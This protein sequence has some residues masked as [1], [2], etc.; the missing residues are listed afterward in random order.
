MRLAHIPVL[1]KG[2][3]YFY[4]ALLMQI[5]HD[6]VHWL[7]GTMMIDGVAREW[8]LRIAWVQ[9]H[10]W[11]SLVGMPQ[12]L[13]SRCALHYILP[14]TKRDFSELCGTSHI[15]RKDLLGY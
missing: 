5:D 10:S 13:R 4:T 15:V 14:C 1:D 12:G 6:Y 7:V 9:G 11:Q 8:R 3:A 2:K